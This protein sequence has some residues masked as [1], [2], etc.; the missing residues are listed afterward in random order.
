M[1]IHHFTHQAVSKHEIYAEI[2][3]QEQRLSDDLIVT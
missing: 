3:L 2:R 1:K